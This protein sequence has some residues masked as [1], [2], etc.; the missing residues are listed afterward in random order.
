MTPR[1]PV[2]LAKWLG[3]AFAAG[4]ALH[5]H[6]VG[7]LRGVEEWVGYALILCWQV[8]PVALAAML[9]KAARTTAGA[10]LFVGFEACFVAAALWF[11]LNVSFNI[12]I[13]GA[14]GAGFFLGFIGPLLQYGALAVIFL[15]ALLFGWRARDGWLKDRT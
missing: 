14:I 12:E 8:G 2:R 10:W 13:W 1:L 9:V 4:S 7:T 5:P 6:L 15:L 11:Y 3:V